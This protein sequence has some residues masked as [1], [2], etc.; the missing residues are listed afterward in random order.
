[1]VIKLTVSQTSGSFPGMREGGVFFIIESKLS[2]NIINYMGTKVQFSLE[3][4]YKGTQCTTQNTYTSGYSK[5][6]HRHYTLFL[7]FARGAG[8]G[9]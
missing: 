4:E 6:K 3:H 1:M 7:L 2:M 8:R 5:I 9:H